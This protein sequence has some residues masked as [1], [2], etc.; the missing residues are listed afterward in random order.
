M[1]KTTHS[2]MVA[3]V[4]LFTT[5]IM[6]QSTVTGTIIDA[7]INS[8]LPGANVI[9]KGTTNGVS[10]DFDGKFTLQTQASSGE[11]VIS[12]VGYSSVTI[13]F[14]GSTDLGNIKL[15]PDNSLEEIVI[16]GTGVIDLAEGRKTPIAVSTIKSEEIREKTGNWDL[17][18]ILK[19]T[20]SVQNIKGG[21]FG[22]GQMF[23][24]GFDQTNTAFMLNGQPINSPEDGRMFWSNW[25]GVLDV[26]NAVQ[27]QR[28]LGSSKL[29]ISSVGGTVNIVTKTVDKKEGGFLQSMVAND[30]YTKTS[31]YYSTGLMESGWAFSALLGHWQGDGY[32]D[33]TDGQGQTYFISVGYKPNE[34]NLFNFMITGAPQWH[35]AAG[36]GRISEFLENGRK[37]NSW[38]FDGVDS[39]NTLK[40]GKYPGG[41][42]IYHK[43]IANLS[44]DLTI[45]DNSS[46][47]TILYG[48]VG[49]GAFAATRTSGGVPTYARGSNNNHNWYGVVSNFET[50]L[51]ENLNLNFGADIRLYN[52]I[53]FRSVNELLSVNSVSAFSDFNGGAYELTETF[54]GL[55]PWDVTFNTNDDHA[56]R[57]GYDYE[58]NINYVG[59]FGQLEY[60][61]DQFSAFFQGSLSTQSHLRTE[62]LNAA[63]EGQPEESAKVNNVGFNVKSGASFTIDDSNKVFVNVGYY[64]RQ[65]FHSDL[66]LSDR[67]GNELIS[68]EVENQKVTGLEAG[69]Q[70]GSDRVSANV[71]LYHTI[72]DN[73]TL[74]S[75][76]GEDQGDPAFRL[77]QTQG[78][79][80]VHSGIELE[81]FMRPTDNLKINGFLSVGNWEFDGMGSLRI[82]NEAGT[83]TDPESEID[84]DGEK[85]GGAAQVTGGLSARLDVLTGLSLDSNWNFYNSLYSNIG[86]GTN[87]LKLPAYDTVDLGVSYKMYVGKNDG[88]SLQFRLNI[89]NAFDEIYLESVSGNDVAAINTSNWKGINT[90]NRG[91]FGYGRTWN[92]SMRYNF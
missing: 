35:A 15:T 49:R 42:N 72:W 69:Y 26:A 59:T 30:N 80:Q 81:V 2:L 66:F 29:A 71:N 20:P 83:E 16:T 4:L 3:V 87:P 79:K 24:R 10:S 52:G 82:Y 56:Q 33:D 53:H 44:W 5:V 22:D 17:P 51:N 25:S 31:A 45:N 77:F 74:L 70:F 23:L 68:P 43:P 55:N 47:S 86:A 64:S 90:S 32:V 78:V 14:S 21:G 18:E 27:V 1:K 36:S 76:N 84:L 11:V 40:S 57:F 85:V 13:S 67:N 50:E 63:N 54:G 91:R 41:R 61:N 8:S 37:F 92:F 9:E 62:Y 75:D 65:P 7:E 88:K 12:Y 28:G 73:R 19:S 58:E 46:L 39:R 38:N 89:N 48:S 6:A 34:N 60:S